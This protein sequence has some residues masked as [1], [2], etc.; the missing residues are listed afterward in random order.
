V[1]VSIQR[2]RDRPLGRPGDRPELEHAAI[3]VLDRAQE[4]IGTGGVALRRTISEGPP[5]RV[6]L[7]A[8]GDADLLV[9]GNRGHGGFAGLLLGSVSQQCAQYAPCP[10]VIVRHGQVHSASAPPSD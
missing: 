8:T 6:L 1:G 3:A 7:E 2:G 10:V 9:V 5:T 4:G